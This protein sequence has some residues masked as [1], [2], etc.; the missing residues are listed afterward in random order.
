MCCPTMCPKVSTRFF[1]GFT[2]G[3]SVRVDAVFS[4]KNPVAVDKFNKSEPTHSGSGS[5]VVL[6]R[7]HSMPDMSRFRYFL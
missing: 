6:M 1:K 3:P 4:I 5:F 7:L 2:N